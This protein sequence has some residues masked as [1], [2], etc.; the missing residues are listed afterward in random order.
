MA[1]SGA[2]CS[3][4]RWP[5][6][7]WHRL[8][9]RPRAG[10]QDFAFNATRKARGE[11]GVML[12]LLFA[13]RKYLRLNRFSTF[14]VRIPFSLGR[15]LLR[16]EGQFS[17]AINRAWPSPRCRYLSS[18]HVQVPV[19]VPTKNEDSM[20]CLDVARGKEKPATPVRSASSEAACVTLGFR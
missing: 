16:L 20:L 7:T 18:G 5:D 14:F 12:V 13:L 3:R 10:T 8:A 17:T 1:L 19:E 4:H 9:S 6:A 11:P 2:A 15:K